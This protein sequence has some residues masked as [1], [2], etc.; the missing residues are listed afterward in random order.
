MISELD[1]CH[2][3]DWDGSN[4]S[5]WLFSEK[6]DGIRIAWDGA[7]L[8][9]RGGV[10]VDAPAWFTSALPVGVALDGELWAGYDT[11]EVARL[12][13]QAGKFAPECVF[14]VH[15]VPEAAGNWSERID[16][17]AGYCNAVVRL[18][19][20]F[21]CRTNGAI[22]K[23]YCMVKRRGGEGLV[24]RNPKAIGYAPGRSRDI[25][26]LKHDYMF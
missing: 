9:T 20:R 11:L 3:R 23:T 6:Y 18:A 24:A 19:E 2:G 14:I 8:W 7:A 12:A 25:A 13:A 15:D 16:T 1:M 26:K 17:A 4:L 5:G 22:R 10:M 21:E